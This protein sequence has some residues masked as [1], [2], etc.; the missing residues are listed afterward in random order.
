V[1]TATT[2]ITN[3]YFSPV[4]NPFGFPTNIQKWTVEVTDTTI[5]SQAVTAP[6][7]GTWYNVGGAAC[8]I[9][10]PIGLWRLGYK[11]DAQVNSTAAATVLDVYLTLSTANNSESDANLTAYQYTAGASASLTILSSLALSRPIA[12]ASKTTNYL[13]AKAVSTPCSIY[14]RNDLVKLLLFAECAY[15]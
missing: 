2:A 3:P 14:L 1:A 15:L 10:A 9:S 6:N 5:R 8:Q 4:K 13:N 7:L 11:V 12:F